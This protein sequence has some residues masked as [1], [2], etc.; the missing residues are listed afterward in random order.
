MISGGAAE[1]L[2][3]VPGAT[4]LLGGALEVTWG[5]GR[6]NLSVCVLYDRGALPRDAHTRGRTMHRGW[7]VVGSVRR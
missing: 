7:D 4:G 6:L 1:G 2:A 5:G 3:E